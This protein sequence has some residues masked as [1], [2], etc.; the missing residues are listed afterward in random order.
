MQLERGG[1]WDLSAAEYVGFRHSSLYDSALCRVDDKPPWQA[2][3]PWALAGH[4]NGTHATMAGW[5]MGNGPGRMAS[6]S[7]TLP[8]AALTSG[9]IGRAAQKPL[10][11]P[12]IV[13]ASWRV[14]RRSPP[15]VGSLL[16]TTHPKVQ[17]LC[18]DALSASGPLRI[19]GL[20]SIAIFFTRAQASQAKGGVGGA[21]SGYWNWQ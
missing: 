6:R 21:P 15:P 9:R 3:A 13:V 2:W 20:A 1:E 14:D 17:T 5:H 18:Y 4:G 16:P 10:A 12:L 7:L 19:Q 8:H 11:R